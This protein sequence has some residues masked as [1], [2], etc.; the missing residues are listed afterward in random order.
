MGR[1]EEVESIK[2]QIDEAFAGAPYP[3]DG[4][5]AYSQHTV[6]GVNLNL[7]FGGKQ[8][9]QISPTLMMLH[10]LLF[11]SPEGF[12][13][14]LPAYLAAALNPENLDIRKDTVFSLAP[15]RP[16]QDSVSNFKERVSQL[17]TIEREAVRHFLLMIRD[18]YSQDFAA[19]VPA[20]DPEGFW[21]K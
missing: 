4:S 20:L 18:L 11:F 1:D 19:D 17:T 12:R 6:D 7:A 3:L 13:Y 2:R 15:L 5:V 10:G 9:N 16:S 21:F 14:F 8:R